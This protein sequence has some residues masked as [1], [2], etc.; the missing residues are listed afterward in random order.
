MGVRAGASVPSAHA[1]LNEAALVIADVMRF[2]PAL[3]EDEL[4]SVWIRLPITFEVQ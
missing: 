3:N 4:V 1:Q 2:S